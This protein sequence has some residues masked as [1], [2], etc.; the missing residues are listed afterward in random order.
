MKVII[1]GLWNAVLIILIKSLVVMLLTHLRICHPFQSQGHLQKEEPNIYLV[2]LTLYAICYYQH[3]LSITYVKRNQQL[4]LTDI[5][6]VRT[7]RKSI[8]LILFLQQGFS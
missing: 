6:F 2:L 1:F 5:E 4:I 8:E 7:C 3:I